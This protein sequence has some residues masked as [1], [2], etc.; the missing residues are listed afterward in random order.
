MYM[1]SAAAIYIK[2]SFYPAIIIIYKGLTNYSKS[3]LCIC[4]YTIP[5]SLFANSNLFL[6]NYAPSISNAFLI[7]SRQQSTIIYNKLEFKYGANLIFKKV[8]NI[9]AIFIGKFCFQMMVIV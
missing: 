3:C 9:Q 6:I 7:D 2:C 8:V 5:T 4:N 1:L